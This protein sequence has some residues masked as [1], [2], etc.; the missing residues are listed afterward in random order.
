MFQQGLEGR[1]EDQSQGR[2][3]ILRDRQNPQDGPP[4]EPHMPSQSGR[5]RESGVGSPG[6]GS[7]SSAALV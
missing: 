3:C 2:I 6:A 4:G 1:V 7:G 5:C